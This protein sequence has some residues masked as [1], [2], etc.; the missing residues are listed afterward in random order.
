MP[1][2]PFSVVF[3]NKA[4]CN[5]SGLDQKSV[6]GKPVGSVLQVNPNFPHWLD[7]TVVPSQFLL[8]GGGELNSKAECQLQ[9][10]PISDCSH[11]IQ[12]M[13]HLL[14]KVLPSTNSVPAPAG[15]TEGCSK[16]LDIEKQ[17]K[18]HADDSRDLHATH[19][20]TIG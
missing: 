6:I 10:L 14:V 20:V 2:P 13:T 1:T 3:I 11:T 5:L 7:G 18:K 19:K 4:F 15:L 16:A 8:S 17:I 9:V 12:V